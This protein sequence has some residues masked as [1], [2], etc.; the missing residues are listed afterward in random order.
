MWCDTYPAPS[1]S[2][3]TSTSPSM[4]RPPTLLPP[5]RPQTPRPARAPRRVGEEGS[6]AGRAPP[7]PRLAARPCAP[8]PPRCARRPIARPPPSTPP[9]ASPR[10]SP[11]PPPRPPLRP[12]APPAPGRMPQVLVP[13][14]A[15]P[16][17]FMHSTQR[18]DRGSLDAAS[19]LHTSEHCIHSQKVQS[20]TCVYFDFLNNFM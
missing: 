12:S 18:G 13:P 9:T 19:V 14:C 5:P 11:R 3:S 16:L 10:P 4:L 15:T 17:A 1:P 6:P 20:C 8:P 2:T 7:P